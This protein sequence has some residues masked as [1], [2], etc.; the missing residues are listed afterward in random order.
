MGPEHLAGLEARF[1]A[2]AV[3][4]AVRRL[5][6]TGSSLADVAEE[7]R[8]EASE[9]VE[10]VSA[11]GGALA[12][13]AVTLVAGPFVGSA[14]GEA[15]AR[16]L[17]RVGHEVE[18]RFLA[19]R[20]ERRIGEAFQAA[21]EAAQKALEAGEEI[22]SDGFFDEARSDEPSPAEEL[23]EGVLRTAADEWEHRKVPYI[24]RMFA[25]VSFDSSISPS[26]ANYLL[27][28][29]DRLTYQ[30]VVLLA[31][32][33]AAQNEERPYRQ[34]VMSASIRKDEGRSRPTAT[35]LAEMN[36]LATAGLLGVTNSD[37]QLVRVGET[38]GGLGGFQTYGGGVHL[39]AVQLTSMGGALYRLMGLDQVPDDDLER[40]AQALHGGP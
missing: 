28:L 40:I 1:I 18:Q 22:R 4:S 39:T 17:L 19:P 35:I 27:K 9:I 11:V 25:T 14:S 3:A 23:L 16:V 2:K 5:S 10:T 20:Q 26:D 36:D 34:E 8:A 37:G 21:T 29:A 30:Q 38:I 33:E 7:K 31:F 24:G 13:T 6:R 12:G 32:W 15:V